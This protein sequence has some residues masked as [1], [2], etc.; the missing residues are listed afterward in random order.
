M[1]STH[2]TRNPGI[3]FLLKPTNKHTS[4]LTLKIDNLKPRK[5]N[6]TDKNQLPTGSPNLVKII[7]NPVLEPKLS[8]LVLLSTTQPPTG[9][10]RSKKQLPSVQ[11]KVLKI[12]KSD[13]Y[14]QSNHPYQ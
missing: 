5:N 2:P 12:K 11:K 7:T 6:L 3:I 4:E 1:F 8:H 14:Q 10:Q 13:P 9:D